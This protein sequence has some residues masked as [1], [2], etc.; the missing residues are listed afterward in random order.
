MTTQQAAMYH[1]T[2]I[3]QKIAEIYALFP[4]AIANQN[5]RNDAE[6][7]YINNRRR[8]RV[9]D[10]TRVNYGLYEIAGEEHAAE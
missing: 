1:A 7:V 10:L 3:G 5:R 8:P 6:V 2:L 4:E 9:F